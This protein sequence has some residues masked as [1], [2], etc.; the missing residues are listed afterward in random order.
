MWYNFTLIKLHVLHP[1][2]GCNKNDLKKKLTKMIKQGVCHTIALPFTLK[3]FLMKKKNY[4]NSNISPCKN[5]IFQKSSK[6]NQNPSGYY[7]SITISSFNT[8][9]KY[10]LSKILI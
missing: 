8:S 5:T 4:G 9:P 10:H 1:L 3:S 6:R 7:N 2:L